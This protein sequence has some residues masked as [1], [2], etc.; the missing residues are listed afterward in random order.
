MIDLHFT[1]FESVFA[2]LHGQNIP[3]LKANNAVMPFD[4]A[5]KFFERL[6]SWSG[7]KD[8]A[9]MFNLTRCKPYAECKLRGPLNSKGK[10]DRWHGWASACDDNVVGVTGVLWDVDNDPDKGFPAVIDPYWF[11]EHVLKTKCV[12]ISTASS[13]PAFPR[14]RIVEPV[15]REMLPEEAKLIAKLRQQRFKK[16]HPEFENVE[17]KTAVDASAEQISHRFY[18]PQQPTKADG[19]AFLKV[20]DGPVFDVDA[21]LASVT[22]KE[23]KDATR[24]KVEPTITSTSHAEML[25]ALWCLQALDPTDEKDRSMSA[26]A[27]HHF[28]DRPFQWWSD[29]ILAVLPGYDTQAKWDK[30]AKREKGVS[31]DSLHAIA[32]KQRRE[33]SVEAS[34]RAEMEA[35]PGAWKKNP[36]SPD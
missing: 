10:P 19:V 3:R 18:L 26:N 13:T 24:K 27:L 11:A 33:K 8:K 20:F 12:V 16:D 21:F 36:A 34:I 2:P 14:A 5:V 17:H 15:T 35:N 1:F 4:M 22:A 28:G 7:S 29:W 31:L 9:S 6:Q 23:R 32:A 25:R 30:C